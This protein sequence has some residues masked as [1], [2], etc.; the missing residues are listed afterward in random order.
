MEDGL[1]TMATCWV[2]NELGDEGFNTVFDSQEIVM[3]R[4]PASE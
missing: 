3:F 2:A 1:W 4:I